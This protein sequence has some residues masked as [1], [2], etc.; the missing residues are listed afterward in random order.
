LVAPAIALLVLVAFLP[1][2]DN[3]FVDWDDDFNFLGNPHYRGLGSVQLKWAWSTFW[4][5]VYQPLA[6]M[7]LEAQYAACQLD[8]LGYHLTS[9]IIHAANA[10]VL[11]ALT[12]VLL[13]A[14]RTD[15]GRGNTWSCYLAAGLATALFAVHPL[16]VEVVAW[17]SCQPY[18]PCTLFS[19]L[20]VLAYLQAART[21]DAARRG[22]LATSLVLFGAALLSKAVAVSLPAVL[23]ILDFYPL[24]RLGGG[25]GM[26]RWFGQAARKVWLEKVPFVLLSLVFV[27]IAIAAKQHLHSLIPIE[28]YSAR[29]RIAQACW[30][31]W[32]YVVKTLWPLD[33][34]P[35]Y[36]L[37]TQIDPT[38]PLFA[39][40]IMGTL[41]LT[42]VLFLL[43]RQRPGLL[44]A[45]LTYLVIL[46]PNS[47][48]FRI[49]DQLA[50]D[51]YS[52]MA[53]LIGVIVAAAGFDR[54]WPA[55]SRLRAGAW[56]ILVVSLLASL[57]LVPLTREQCRIWRS[58]VTLWTHALNHGMGASSKAHNGL[59]VALF[60]QGR[61]AEAAAHYEQ[62]LRLD[63]RDAEAYNNQAMLLAACPDERYRDGQRAVQYAISACR[64]TGWMSPYFVDTLAAA[65]AEAGDFDA[66][67]AWQSRAIDLLSGQW[68]RDAY[69]ARLALYQARKP[70][71]AAV[72][73]RLAGDEHR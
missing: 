2:L 8:P 51:R 41:A 57:V 12:V 46:A 55:L 58:P 38:A 1:I 35:V 34:S 29:A 62:A 71:R 48:L 27:V 36:P 69:R 63:P 17:V 56:G 68:R 7:L 14:S 9:L 20:A 11:C 39:A 42:A 10:V 49:S 28:Q 53:T 66:A 19:M 30:G 25:R 65:H 52:Y 61:F 67:V 6:W 4:F 54:L 15:A 16:R 31:I 70:F 59:G 37:P 44:A 24:R 50:A 3:G 22:W 64:L 43:R 72:A 32:F 73:G 13:V 60:G 45:W 5:G 33:L 23:L 26:G 18:L 21:G 47:G 40:S